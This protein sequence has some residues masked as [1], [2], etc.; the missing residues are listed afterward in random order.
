MLKLLRK[1]PNG[2]WTHVERART[3]AWSVG[4]TLPE[5]Y[6]LY[7]LV[8]RQRPRYILELG[9]GIS[10]IVLGFAALRLTDEGSPCTV[11]TYEESAEFASD[12]ASFIPD[13]I[14]HHVVFHVESPIVRELSDS[15]ASVSFPNKEPLPYDLVVVD[16]PQY[17]DKICVNTSLRKAFDGDALDVL[18]WQPEPF[19][20]VVDGR[21]Q[22]VKAFEELAPYGRR[23][24]GRAFPRLLAWPPIGPFSIGPFS[25]RLASRLAKVTAQS[26]LRALFPV[27]FHVWAVPARAHRSTPPPPHA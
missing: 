17:E 21:K 7:T 19:G 4:L 23:W 14:R 26:P 3:E 11:H 2:M 27:A 8:L 10:S 13:K 18:E 22:T 9:S 15:W 16:G 6:F 20:V 12:L 25:A 1:D 24:K 5:F